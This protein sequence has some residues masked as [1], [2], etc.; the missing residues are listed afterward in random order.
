[1]NIK[2]RSV[3]AFGAIAVIASTLFDAALATAATHDNSVAADTANNRANMKAERAANRAF[4]HR[5]YT[6][7]ARTNGLQSTDIVVFA[8]ADTGEVILSGM[9]SDASQDQLASDVA[10]KVQGVT[11]VSSKMTIREQGS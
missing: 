8:M 11:S 6:Q 4:A 2:S 1:M 5:I 10:R 7:L 9:I 3:L